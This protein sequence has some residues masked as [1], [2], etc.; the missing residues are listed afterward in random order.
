M[1]CLVFVVGG[2]V[3]LTSLLNK[4]S[5]FPRITLGFQDQLYDKHG[6]DWGL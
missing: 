2:V 4:S 3:C 6:L 1:S 5:V